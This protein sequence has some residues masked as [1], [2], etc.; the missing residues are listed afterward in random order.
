MTQRLPIPGSDQG[1]W[2][3][4]LNGFLQVSLNADGT[5]QTTA[6]TQ[7]GGVTSV[8]GQTPTS[9]AVTLTAANVSALPTSTKLSGL[10]DT[11]AATSASNGQVLAFNSSS[12]QWIPSTVSSTTVNNA[13][14][15]TPGL[16]QLAGDLAGTATTPTVAKV[17]G[18]AVSGTP[19]SGQVITA[20]SSSAAA[21]STPG[22]A[23]VSSVFGRT[24]AVTA[25]TGDYTA[26]QVTGALVNTNN[27][28]DVSSTSTARTNLG[29]GSAATQA[30]SAFDASGAAA[31]V[32]AA[33]LQ[34]TSNLSDVSSA[35]T[36][37]TN[38]GLGSAATISS[39]AGGDLS[40][41]LPSPT[42]AK[43]NGVAVTGTPSTGQVITASSSSAA[44]WSTP[45]SGGAQ[46]LTPTAVKTSAYSPA[47]GDFVPV[48]ASS[49]SVT[50]TLPTAPADKSRI[51]IKMINVAS[52]NTVTINTGGSDVFNKAGG[53]TTATLS[54]LNQA[55]MI[56][57]AA[58]PAIWYVQS[59]DLPLTQLDSRYVEE[60]NI[61]TAAQMR[62]TVGAPIVLASDQAGDL[63]WD[64]ST[65]T[66]YGPLSSSVPSLGQPWNSTG[67]RVALATVPTFAQT[68]TPEYNFSGPPTNVTLP[69]CSAGNTLVLWISKS[70][71]TST[72]VSGGPSGVT[73]TKVAS[74]YDSTNSGAAEIW[75]GTGYATS[76]STINPTITATGNFNGYAGLGEVTGILTSSAVDTNYGTLYTGNMSQT[77][78]TNAPN[79]LVVAVPCDISGNSLTSPSLPNI[80]NG[81]QGYNMGWGVFNS[82]T[83][84]ASVTWT[85]QFNTDHTGMAVV[86]LLSK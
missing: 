75:L 74:V 30:T 78:T 21:W 13:T 51:E 29:L 43:V 35:S 11:S 8:N 9:G 64:N 7:A 77:I 26:A 31:T 67:V 33:S 86:T 42:V 48:D 58:T 46:N 3:S 55:V 59:D 66:I 62:S 68:G 70:T 65:H 25:T 39:T 84:V 85:A 22:S 27:L 32:Q 52:T 40:G 82:P 44:T 17:N 20:S 79:D 6:I 15:S 34:K 54:L 69:S 23:P 19:S 57:Y 49:A 45:S 41:T 1:T 14:T 60:S 80:V 83:T 63:A 73:W 36:A 61:Q 71:V 56:Q 37:R 24:G 28:S 76:G 16:I 53:T 47:A 10:A 18:V 50:I 81:T 5:L 2:G 38:L 72:T 12:N 4:I